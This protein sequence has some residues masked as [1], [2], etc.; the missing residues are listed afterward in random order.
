[1]IL[2]IGIEDMVTQNKRYFFSKFLKTLRT[3]T[4]IN[5]VKILDG[6]Q[7]IKRMSSIIVLNYAKV[8]RKN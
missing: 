1:M 3:S 8:G 6:F 7:A 4:L 5:L 2:I